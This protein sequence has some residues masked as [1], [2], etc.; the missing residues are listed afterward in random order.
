MALPHIILFAD[1]TCSGAHTHI[2]EAIS[3][4]ESSFNDITS[5]FV[6]LEG[7][8]EFFEDINFANQ[9]GNFAG[10]HSG[11]LGPGVYNWIEDANALG[12]DTNDKLSSLRPV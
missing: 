7:N 5:S 2:N 11:T 9:M 8:W 6:I 4:L 1:I 3:S 10:G 12:G